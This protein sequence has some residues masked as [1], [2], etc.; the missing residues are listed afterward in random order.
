[1]NP[2]VESFLHVPSS[3]WTHLVIDP[4]TQTA[5]L[6]DAVLDFDYPSGAIATDS[7]A[8]VIARIRALDLKLEWILETHAHADHLSAAPHIRDALGGR[9]AI[10]ECIRQVQAHFST[11]LNFEAG[12][13]NDGSQFDHLF[14]DG[15]HFRIG[16]L[17]VR[18]IATPG[19]TLDSVSYLIGDAL[20]VGDTLFMPDG[21]TAR[22][23]FPGGDSGLL[24]DSIHKLY[25]LPEDTRLF[26]CHDY[27][28]GGRAHHY[29]SSIGEQRRGNIHMRDGIS[30]SQFIAMRGARD[31]ALGMP[32]LLYPSVQVN[33]RGGE[34]PPVESNGQA[35]LKVPLQGQVRKSA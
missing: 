16:H 13:R 5:A 35:Y 17:D 6:V 10:G 22:C 9:I 30:R 23:D 11:A 15:E 21:G 18:V 28:P 32:A 20:F 2:V 25:K 4:A 27:A 12:F 14:K 33:V 3:T 31:R 1:M 26:V 34:F 24:Y 29:L 8:G 7:A 19:H